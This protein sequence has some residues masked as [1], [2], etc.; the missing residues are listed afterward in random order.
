MSI[1]QQWL[2]TVTIPKQ[3]DEEYKKR[4]YNSLE[5]LKDN[6]KMV[7]DNPT[8]EGKDNYSELSDEEYLEF[9]DVLWNCNK[10]VNVSAFLEPVGL[11]Y[12]IEDGQLK[13]RAVECDHAIYTTSLK[14][15]VIPHDLVE[16]SAP[17]LSTLYLCI[18]YIVKES[19]KINFEDKEYNVYKICYGTNTQ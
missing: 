19:K 10:L 16:K 3:F 15:H 13:T 2:S 5:L 18:F 4:F 17:F 8:N 11:A 7:L 6:A 12:I 1:L 14:N 9:F